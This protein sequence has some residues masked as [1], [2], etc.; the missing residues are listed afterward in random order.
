MLFCTFI[1]NYFFMPNKICFKCGQSKPLDD[2]YKH[3]QMGDGHLN[4]CKE[5]NKKDVKDNYEKNILD[6]AFIKKERKRGRNKYH[7]LYEGTGKGNAK[8]NSDYFKRYPEKKI[9]HMR[10]QRME[11]PT[12]FEKHHFSY[13]PE[14]WFEVIFLTKQHHMK[15]HRFLFYDQERMMYRRYDTNELLDTKEKH[16]AFIDHCILNEE[17]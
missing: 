8:V 1:G 16:K 5:C 14:H 7:R 4:K 6:P 12:G 10:A 13:Q 17:D 15:A 3:A 11:L 2:F 9:A